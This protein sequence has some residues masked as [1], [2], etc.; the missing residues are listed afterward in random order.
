MSANSVFKI[1][2]ASCGTVYGK[3]LNTTDA[4]EFLTLISGPT[5]AQSMIII[6][7]SGMYRVEKLTNDLER[8]FV[9]KDIFSSRGHTGWE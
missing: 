5:A 3:A 7:S 9:K 6:T 2:A 1:N 4:Q 8:A